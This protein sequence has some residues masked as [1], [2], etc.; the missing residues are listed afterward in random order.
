MTCFFSELDHTVIFK[1]HN[2]TKYQDSKGFIF[3][4]LSIKGNTLL[5]ALCL[6]AETTIV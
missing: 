4:L 3:P 6:K 5:S 2:T 1:N